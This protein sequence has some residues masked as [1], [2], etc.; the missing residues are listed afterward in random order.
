MCI[1]VINDWRRKS[2]TRVE[3]NRT[4]KLWISWES[5]FLK[6]IE[7]NVQWQETRTAYQGSATA[8][9]VRTGIHKLWPAGQIQ[10]LPD[11]LWPASWKWLFCLFVCLFENGF[12]VS[13]GK[14]ECLGQKKYQEKGITGRKMCLHD[15][16][17]EMWWSSGGAWDPPGNHLSLTWSRPMTGGA[18]RLLGRSHRRAGG[19]WRGW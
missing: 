16:I 19:Y 4:R 14:Q 11:F 9:R 1:H 6:E 8:L 3:S 15:Q 10:T 13:G 17:R 12:W 7:Q 2:D 18:R 5:L